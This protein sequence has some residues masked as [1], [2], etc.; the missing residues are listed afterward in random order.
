M[1]VKINV[2]NEMK[3]LRETTYSNKYAWVKEIIQ[4]CQR[5]S[6]SHIK[7]TLTRDTVIIEDNGVGCTNPETL[8]E[9]NISGWNNNIK[10]NENPFGEG[11]FSTLMAAN[12]IIVESIGFKCT[13]DVKR[14]FEENT[15]DVIKVEESN[16]KNGF[17]I[18]LT[19]WLDNIDYYGILCAFDN[20][21]KY[22]KK[23]KIVINGD[24]IKYEGLNPNSNKPFIHYINNKYFSGWIR[25]HSWKNGDWDTCSVKCFAF[26]RLIKDSTITTGVCGV[27]N[28]K[29]NSVNLR[30]PDR[31][32]FIFDTLYDNAYENFLDEVRKMCIKI[33]KFGTDTQIQNFDTFIDKYVNVDDYKRFIKFKFIGRNVGQVNSVKIVE[34]I[35]STFLKTSPINNTITNIDNVPYDT[36]D[37]DMEVSTPVCSVK[38]GRK[39]IEYNNI[40]C[41]QSGDKL[42]GR[43]SYGF[44]VKSDE[45]SNY[46]D[47]I[48]IAEYYSIPIVEIRNRL[49]ENVISQNRKF[50]HISEL[51]NNIYL[52]CKYSNSKPKT[53]YEIRVLKVL[54]KLM[55]AIN[56]KSDLF[57]ICD[58]DVNRIL[59]I[60]NQVKPI[61]HIDTLA[62]AYKGKIYLNRKHLCAYRNLKDDA[63]NLTID[64]IRFVML[65]LETFCHEMSHALYGNEDNTRSHLECINY[66]MQKLINVIF[67]YGNKSICI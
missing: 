1:E 16:K 66:L 55:E 8:F 29:P 53:I 12:K 4:N 40:N 30:S 58:T 47:H 48:A 11:F 50:Q 23:P 51:A 57:I 10:N 64:D 49:E 2:I 39:K 42:D 67:N 22:I 33:V 9:K 34:E 46:T 65:N 7:V 3:K 19:D 27:L 45:V 21:G 6:A 24:R 18:I 60:N 15:V 5:A 25:P 56:V 52:N 13:F 35:D 26:D 17:T 41:N 61:E 62:T 38:R 20:V 44:Y 37:Y 43:S 63:K 31:E 32:E 36:T 59:K 14:M 28:F 54:N